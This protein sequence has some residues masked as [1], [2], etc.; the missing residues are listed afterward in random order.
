MPTACS[1]F[2]HLSSRHAELCAK[3]LDSEVSAELA[4]PAGFSPDLDKLAAFRLLFHAEIETFLEAKAVERLSIIKSDIDSGVWHRANP[5]VLSLYLLVKNFIQKD[6]ALSDDDL[7]AHFLS[8][9]G[10][11][12]SRVKESNGIKSDA[13]TFLSV[14]AGKTLDEIDLT[15]LSALNSY[16]KHRGDVAHS[17]A[18]R[19]RSLVAPSSE[20]KTSFE[21]VTQ[22]AE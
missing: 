1:H 22:L 19:V 17:S 7:K 15:L 12:R 4:D 9:L 18:I 13:F 6:G 14:A 21:L 3:F 20:R 8:V 11:A 5:C 2:G 16:G 10:S